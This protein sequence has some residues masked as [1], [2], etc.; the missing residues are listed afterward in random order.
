MTK[1]VAGIGCCAV[2]AG[3]LL[4]S[5]GS[6]RGRAQTEGCT[7]RKQVY[8]CDRA[9]FQPVLAA[10]TTVQIEAAA[11]DRV[12]AAKLR[13][14]VVSLGKSVVPEGGQGDLV[15]SLVRLESDGVLVGPAGTELAVLRVYG[16][17]VNGAR[18]NLLWAETLFGQPDMTWPV[19]VQSV[20]DQF[21]AG[22]KRKA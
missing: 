13:D 11:R 9:Q 12:A 6:V 17:S 1:K 14:L 8:T 4:G 3:M 5:S 16:P 15:F 2:W 22:F 21:R 7:L 18:G 19:V 10:A 20:I